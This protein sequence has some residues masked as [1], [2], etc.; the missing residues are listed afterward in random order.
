MKKIS[1]V[2]I[3][4]LILW[5]SYLTYKLYQLSS[6]PKE[7]VKSDDTVEVTRVYTTDLT[8]ATAMSESKVV[9]VKS[10][11]GEELKNHGS[12]AVVSYDEGVVQ[13]LTNAHVVADSESIKVIF[14]N[15]EELEGTLVVIDTYSDIAIVQV[16]CPFEVMPF[17]FANS[18]NIK[19][20]D[21]VLA[22]GS[23]INDSLQGTV[24]FG[25]I[26]GKDR[27]IEMD[28]DQDGIKDWDMYVL[29]SDAAINPGSSGGPLVDI[30]GELVGITSSKVAG[31]NIE[32]IGFAIPSNE[33]VSIMKQLIEN[34]SVIRP[35]FG[36]NGKDVRN[37]TVYQKSYLGIG[38]EVLDGILVTN[39]QE[40]SPAYKAGIMV[41]DIITRFNDLDVEDMTDFRQLL[42]GA[43]VGESINITLMRGMD[44]VSVVVVLE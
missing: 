22:M 37:L 39:I 18:D 9:S 23:P 41:N 7:N 4:A 43:S 44:E 12:G 14:N 10:Y 2:L 36:M 33:L 21:Y 32:G 29:Q 11:V 13:L 6:E 20:G 34:G 1:I 5:N 19:K 35:V 17:T 40:N 42:Y 24:T 38:L 27:L 31:S 3:T 26:S 15:Y 16:E 25:I 28:I 8:N 30:S